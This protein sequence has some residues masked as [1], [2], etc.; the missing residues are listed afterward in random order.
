[1]GLTDPKARR[2][3]KQERYWLRNTVIFTVGCYFGYFTLKKIQ[4]GSLQKQFLTIKDH[5]SGL[6]T[7]HVVEPITKLGEEFQT[8]FL[9]NSMQCNRMLNVCLPFFLSFFLLPFLFVYLSM[10]FNRISLFISPSFFLSVFLS[11]FLSI[12]L[13]FF[14]FYFLIYFVFLLS[15]LSI[16]RICL[17]LYFVS[18]RLKNQVKSFLR[19]YTEEKESLAEKT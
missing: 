18:D 17:I 15:I 13:S 1:M 16:F 11:L 19:S 9:F 3:P 6:L 4:N 5:L 14:S 8:I 2:P 7:E 12:F 10:F